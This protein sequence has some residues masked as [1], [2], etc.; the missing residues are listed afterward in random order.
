MPRNMKN[1]CDYDSNQIVRPLYPFERAPEYLS[2][3]E[4]LDPS[5]CLVTYSS[6]PIRKRAFLTPA[7]N[8]GRDKSAKS[9][10]LKMLANHERWIPVIRR[11]LA[12]GE[13]YMTIAEALNTS[14]KS[15]AVC[16]QMHNLR[17]ER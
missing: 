8:L 3:V 17:G 5:F 14:P 2:T 12:N 9:R 13:M 1:K 10:R 11:M 16:M 15:L 7:S 4:L 6:A